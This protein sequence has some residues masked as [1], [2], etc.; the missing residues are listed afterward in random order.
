MLKWLIK[1]IL[2]R[3]KSK[4][5]EMFGSLMKQKEIHHFKALESICDVLDY[6]R[7]PITEHVREKGEIPYYGASGI[8]DYVKDSIFDEELLLVSEDGANLVSR[9]TPIAFSIS[10]KSWVNNHVHVLRFSNMSLQRYVEIF[11]NVTDLNACINKNANPKLTQQALKSILVPI[12]KE[13]ELED[14][15]NI[16]KSIDKLKFVYIYF[17]IEI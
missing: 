16:V 17:D 14:F 2:V 10:G 5:V 11:L 9:K 3:E 6:R 7:Q 8:V 13:T 1:N 4:F 12:P 15:F